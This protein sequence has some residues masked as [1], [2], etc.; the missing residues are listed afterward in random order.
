MFK[1]EKRVPIKQRRTLFHIFSDLQDIRLDKTNQGVALYIDD[2]VQFVESEERIYHD[3]LAGV[4]VRKRGKG[5]S[6]IILG[7]GDGLAARTAYESGASRVFICE[8]DPLMIWLASHNQEMR[9]L[10]KDV[11]RRCEV[12][13][14]DAKIFVRSGA[15]RCVDVVICDFPDL[16]VSTMDLYSPQMYSHIRRLLKPGGLISVYPGGQ[17]LLVRDLINRE[18]KDI[19]ETT[20]S[21][22][23]MGVTPIICARKR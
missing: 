1:V 23:T 2:E 15:D 11:M 19:S 13:I 16:K 18:F 9:R 14:C 12:L 8:I 10:N 5:C 17:Y 7:G 22:S 4:P 21:L 3:A 20:I 6:V